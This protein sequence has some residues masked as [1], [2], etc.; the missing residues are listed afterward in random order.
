MKNT[1]RTKRTRMYRLSV[2]MAIL[3]L[4]VVQACNCCSPPPPPKDTPTP[5]TEPPATEPTEATEEPPVGAGDAGGLKSD[6][7][8][9]RSATRVWAGP[10]GAST[11]PELNDGGWHDLGAGSLVTTDANGEGWVQF[12]DCMLIYVF[13]TSKLRKSACP[14]SSLTGGNVTCAEEGTSAFNNQCASQIIIQT[15]TI[16]LELN[17]TW[18]KVSYLPDLQLSVV[19][20]WEGSATVWPVLDAEDYSLG[21]VDEVDEGR[22]WFTVPDDVLGEMGDLPVRSSLDNLPPVIEE[23][24]QPWQ[25]QALARAEDDDV[26]PPVPPPASTQVILVSGGGPFE[27]RRVREAIWYAVPWAGL[28]EEIFGQDLPAIMGWMPEEGGLAEPELVYMIEEPDARNLEYDPEQAKML[29][30][31]SGYPDG[32][33]VRLMYEHDEELAV[34]AEIIQANLYDVD[35]EVELYVPT[36]EEL[37]ERSADEL[38]SLMVSAGKPVLWLSRQ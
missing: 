20:V 11:L 36:S 37:S 31:E 33:F 10:G 9:K 30:A 16:Q 29:L 6:A 14:R 24:L 17:G 12:S 7:Q 23:R 18:L 15:P 3:V 28:S 35:I 25:A 38:V 22:S 5:K 19:E 8:V 2:V 13:R 21:N 26:S 34:L 32:L 1:V 4:L 27:D